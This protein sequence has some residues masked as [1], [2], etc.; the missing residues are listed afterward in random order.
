M[1]RVDIEKTRHRFVIT[2]DVHRHILEVNRKAKE[3]WDKKQAVEAEKL[4]KVNEVIYCFLQLSFTT[5]YCYHYVLSKF[6]WFL[7]SKSPF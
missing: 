3:E 5:I 6:K 2:S 7:I 1:K 4:R